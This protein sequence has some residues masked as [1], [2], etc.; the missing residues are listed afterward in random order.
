MRNM[1]RAWMLVLCAAMLLPAL[2]CDDTPASPEEEAAIEKAVAGYLGALAEAYSSASVE[3]LRGYA[4]PNEMLAVQKLLKGLVAT[5]DRVESTLLGFEVDALE[6][7]RAVNATV[8]LLEV[9]EV[10][11]YDAYSG[12]EKGRNPESIQNSILQLRKVDGRWLVTA[13]M[14]TQQDAGP[15]AAEGEGA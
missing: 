4:S 8:R 10:V 1:P 12:V 11:R 15:P 6:V 5:G 14:I 7:F 2:A 9:W 3:P 13:R